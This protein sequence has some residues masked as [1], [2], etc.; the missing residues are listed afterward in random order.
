MSKYCELKA[1]SLKRSLSRRG[2]KIAFTIEE[3]PEIGLESLEEYLSLFIA[4]VL[5]K[6]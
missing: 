2:K 5:K 6:S 1:K 4:F 3:K